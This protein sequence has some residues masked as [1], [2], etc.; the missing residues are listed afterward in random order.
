MQAHQLPAWTTPILAFCLSLILGVV[1]LPSLG[2]VNYSQYDFWLLWFVTMVVLA[3]PVM[4]LEIALAKRAKDTPL[5]AFMQLTRD[6]DRSTRWRLIGWAAVIFAPFIVGAILNYVVQQLQ[7]AFAINTASS[8]LILVILIVA[9]AASML[10][11]IVLFAITLLATLAVAGLG[12]AQSMAHAH[13]QWTT[14]EFSEW[15]KVVTLT[16]V[17][18]GLGL[19]FYWQGTVHAVKAQQKSMP[20]VLPIWLAQVVGLGLLSLIHSNTSMPYTIAMLMAALGLSGLLL[21]FTREQLLQRKIALPIQAIV[22]IVPA[23][24]WAI[25]NTAFAFYHILIFVGLILCLGY[26]IF[27]GWLMKI[28]HLRKAINFSSEAVYS[29]WRVMIRII[30]PVSILL[31]LIGWILA[32]VGV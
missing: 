1:L 31:A 9:V 25:P 20:I 24:I 8:L 18:G 30:V 6:A 4:I 10:P 3:L 26:A 22:L 19:G 32:L 28:S 29:F 27:V 15:A 2:L 16:L 13:W 23:L 12:I 11:R 17:T 21:Q 14:I 7:L 5:V